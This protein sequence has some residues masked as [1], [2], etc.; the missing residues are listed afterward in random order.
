MKQLLT[1]VVPRIAAKGDKVAHFMEFS[2]SSIKIIRQCRDDPEECC[3]QLL[4]KWIGTDQGVTPK[5][6]ATLLSVIKQVK[7]LANVCNEIER[8]S[9]CK[10]RISISLFNKALHHHPKA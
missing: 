7:T 1:S 6:W 8:I 4:K 10:I 5:N 2:I 3:Y 9:S